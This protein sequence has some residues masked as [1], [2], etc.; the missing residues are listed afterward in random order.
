MNVYYFLLLLCI[1]FYSC[2]KKNK[3]EEKEDFLAI[4]R[5]KDT[6]TEEKKSQIIKILDKEGKEM[7]N[8][9]LNEREAYLKY[10]KLKESLTG[11]YTESNKTKYFNASG[12]VLA[13]IKYEKTGF[14]LFQPNNLLLWCV[15]YE[16]ENIKIA[17]N[18]RMRSAFEIKKQGNT[19]K[20]FAPDKMWGEININKGKL[21]IKGNIIWE[22]ATTKIHPAYASLLISPIPESL[23]MIIWLEMLRKK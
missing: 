7:L 14:S 16:E 8:L 13:V 2:G 12:D 1:T 19:Y 5:N 11:Q 18:Q 15:E 10:D 21:W 23:R 4:N 6:K 22:T 9:D 17:D 3:I 20:V